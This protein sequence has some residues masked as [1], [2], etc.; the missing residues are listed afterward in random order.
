[1]NTNQTPTLFADVVK[2][3][4]TK[5]TPV[6]VDGLGVFVL[7]NGAV[8]FIADVAPRV[9]IA[10]VCE[11][12]PFALRLANA[13]EAAGMKPWLDCRKLRPGQNWPAAI[14]RAIETSDFFVP[15][16]SRRALRKRGHFPYELRLALRCAER[17]PLEQSFIAP[18]RL[19]A[20]NVPS[21]IE[22]KIAY[23]DLFPDWD[24]GASRLID[25]LWQEFSLRAA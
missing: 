18:V 19:E 21:A 15:C 9:F 16:F 6:E 5:G 2:Q 22:S 13:L 4:L 7:Q 10:Y 24:V 23:V 1:M 25:S 8:R 3:A 12:K 14:E 11:D 20:C 17:M